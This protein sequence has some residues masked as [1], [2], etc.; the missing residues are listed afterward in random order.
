[1]LF[2]ELYFFRRLDF[3]NVDPM[4]IDS[5]VAC[6]FNDSND[7]MVK[8]FYAAFASGPLMSREFLFLNKITTREDPDD[9]VYSSFSFF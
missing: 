3:E 6:R 7:Q 1:M 9:Q 5:W 8:I 4:H 2:I